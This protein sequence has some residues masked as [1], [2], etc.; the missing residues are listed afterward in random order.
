MVAVVPEVVGTNMDLSAV[1][2]MVLATDIA[3]AVGTV[4]HVVHPYNFP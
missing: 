2:V 1:V 4:L 3:L